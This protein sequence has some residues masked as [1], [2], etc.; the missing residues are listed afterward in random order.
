MELGGSQR[1]APT[2]GAML[3]E[4]LLQLPNVNFDTG[5]MIQP[6]T[7]FN[8]E[9]CSMRT[10]GSDTPARGPGLNKVSDIR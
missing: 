8:W 7:Y 3:L 1:L 2:M 4:R 6:G 9:F 5:S 10:L